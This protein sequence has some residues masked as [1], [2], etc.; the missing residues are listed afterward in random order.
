MHTHTHT[1]TRTHTYTHTH[2]G[3]ETGLRHCISAFQVMDGLGA[4][5]FGSEAQAVQHACHLMRLYAGVQGMY[6]VGR[7][8]SAAKGLYTLP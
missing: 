7:A 6:K 3:S 2:T 5:V 8:G 1:C 4:P